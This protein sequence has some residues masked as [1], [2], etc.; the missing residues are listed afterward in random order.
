MSDHARELRR[1]E[2]ARLKEQLISCRADLDRAGEW[3]KGTLWYADRVREE[4]WL[5]LAIARMEAAGA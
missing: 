2:L 5:V 4:H 1:A 3:R